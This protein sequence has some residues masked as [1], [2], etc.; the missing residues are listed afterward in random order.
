MFV[1]MNEAIPVWLQII[2]TLALYFFPL[3]LLFNIL[4]Q[5]YGIGPD[6]GMG[7]VM[8]HFIMGTA[9]ILLLLVLVF[10]L[11]VF[12]SEVFSTLESDAGE[13]VLTQE[14]FFRMML[15]CLINLLPVLLA[16]VFLV[17]WR[18][19]QYR[20]VKLAFMTALLISAGMD[21]YLW[22]LV[23]KILRFRR[24]EMARQRGLLLLFPNLLYLNL[25]LLASL[26]VCLERVGV[27]SWG[28][29]GLLIP[30][31]LAS[32]CMSY[33]IVAYARSG[34]VECMA[35]GFGAGIGCYPNSQGR[36]VSGFMLT[37]G[38]MVLGLIL[39]GLLIISLILP[40]FAFFRIFMGE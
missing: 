30:L 25:L 33:L 28:L 26:Y 16:L 7:S 35:R 5:V 29:L 22:C 40:V 13:Y 23:K 36:W 1:R 31:L 17:G 3:W 18:G 27:C 20:V 24:V 4:L 32:P 37:M 38:P 8:T 34:G 11:Y 10:Y 14:R 12:K 9:Q 19:I 15:I 2:K 6:A 21:L 39:A